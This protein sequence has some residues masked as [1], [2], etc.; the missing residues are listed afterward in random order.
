MSFADNTVLLYDSFLVPLDIRIV[1]ARSKLNRLVSVKV[2]T[3]ELSSFDRE[4]QLNRVYY[5]TNVNK[6]N[7]LVVVYRINLSLYS[8]QLKCIIKS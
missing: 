2:F 1:Q 5:F 3:T 7:Q 6:C 4:K 8:A